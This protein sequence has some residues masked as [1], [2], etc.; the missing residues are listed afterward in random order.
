MSNAGRPRTKRLA[1]VALAALLVGSASAEIVGPGTFRAA[2]HVDRWGQRRFGFLFVDAALHERLA[3]FLGKTVAID[4][5][6]LDDDNGWLATKVG[7]V[8]PLP[9]DLRFSVA[10]KP[11]DG[12]VSTEALQVADGAMVRVEATIANVTDHVVALNVDW[13]DAL[14][15]EVA[16]R[17]AV[18]PSEFW[19]GA[20]GQSSGLSEQGPPL[21]I[22]RK[23]LAVGLDDVAFD[24][25]TKPG[26]PPAGRPIRPEATQSKRPKTTRTLAAGASLR[27][28]AT[29]SHLPTNEY[30]IALIRTERAENG[31]QPTTTESRS[32]TL[33][34]DVIETE[35]KASG[36]LRID[37]DRAPAD[38]KPKVGGVPLRATFVNTTAKTLCFEVPRKRDLSDWIVA[39]DAVGT[40]VHGTLR[41]D[42]EKADAVRLAP[43]ASTTFDVEVPRETKLARIVW[44]CG[45]SDADEKNGELALPLGW[46]VSRHVKL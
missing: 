29:L 15:I 30:E 23:R 22:C 27:F 25:A 5:Q 37:V 14:D 26:G 9:Q 1:A 36:G 31:G 39:Y 11:A 33:R 20:S 19:S 13:T 17:T 24:A 41:Q 12:D 6:A 28:V 18:D 3:P 21:N 8:D 38:V 32:N 45:R 16:A 42:F 35:S 10:W 44:W 4:V 7:A 43:G 34:L 40:L 46:H 2:Y